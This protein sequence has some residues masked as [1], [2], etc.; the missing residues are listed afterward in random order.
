MSAP[1]RDPLVQFIGRV[2]IDGIACPSRGGADAPS[3][4]GRRVDGLAVEVVRQQG[5]RGPPELLYASDPEV[6]PT[7]SLKYR[8][9]SKEASRTNRASSRATSPMRSRAN[10]RTSRR[11]FRLPDEVPPVPVFLE[12]VGFD[13]P[14]TFLAVPGDEFSVSEADDAPFSYGGHQGGNV[15]GAQRLGRLFELDVLVDSCPAL[16]RTRSKMRPMALWYCWK[17]G[18]SRNWRRV[19]VANRRAWRSCSCRL[20][21][22]ML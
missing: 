6:M 19:R 8:S 15:L 7:V 17:T 14:L 12:Q 20:S 9:A 13:A 21:P 18:M 4:A 5:S 3:G 1:N 22:L 10:V 11:P 16:W 2:D